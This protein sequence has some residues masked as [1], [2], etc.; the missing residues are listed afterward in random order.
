MDKVDVLDANGN[1]T[2]LVSKEDIEK[3][4]LSAN[5]EKLLQARDTPLQQELLRSL[6]GERMEYETWEKILK[7]EV[8]M[9]DNVEEGT[10]LWFHA[11]Q[12]FEENPVRIEWSTEE[13]FESWK[14]M[15]E[16]KGYRQP[17]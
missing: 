5:K 8:Y 11:I 6:L 9:P 16:T 12:N 17:T 3:A 10:K 13:Y 1:L 4:I 14:P 15:S 7:K 2:T